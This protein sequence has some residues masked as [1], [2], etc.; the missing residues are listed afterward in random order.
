MPF[1][2]NS[3]KANIEDNG[4]LK[5]NQ[6]EVIVTPPPILFAG[7]LNMLGTSTGVKNVLDSMKYRI[8][9]VRAPGISLISTDVSRYGVGPT[10]KQP[11]NA[12]YQDL[13]FSILVD[14]YGDTWQFWYNWVRAI[15][16][17]NGTESVF[18]NSG[19]N[20]LPTYT[21]EYKEKYAT[22]MQIIIYD[23]FGNSIQKVNLYEAW[24]SSVREVSL[25]WGQGDLMRISVSVT[26][27]GFTLVG[28]AI[29]NFIGGA[30]LSATESQLL[31][32]INIF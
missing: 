16:Q 25:T 14:G 5:T 29:E 3:F 12:Q 24:P 32:K 19:S 6:F 7:S 18:T 27:S 4:Y 26:Y 21:A 11:F 9:Q 15:F 2:I 17:F 10:Q 1:N 20:R 23:N 31:N 8:E 30:L 13:T 22:T 28:S